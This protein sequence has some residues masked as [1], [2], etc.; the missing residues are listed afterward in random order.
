MCPL[1]LVCSG[2]GGS[3]CNK[4]PCTLALLLDGRGQGKKFHS[5]S[6][7]AH[8]F[9]QKQS[10]AETGQHL[11]SR[12]LLC[13][14]R[15]SAQQLSPLTS[16]VRIS[17]IYSR[18]RQR[19]LWIHHLRRRDCCVKHITLCCRFVTSCRSLEKEGGKQQLKSRPAAGPKHQKRAV[20]CDSS[21]LFV[22]ESL[23]TH[24]KRNA[25]WSRTDIQHH[26]TK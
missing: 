6:R 13:S 11:N 24:Q 22:S 7:R 9:K 16:S 8:C 19:Y 25:L 2:M 14:S 1:L 10:R 23:P 21:L 26:R 15:F 12:I 5:K 20:G 4:L 3:C 18:T 17:R